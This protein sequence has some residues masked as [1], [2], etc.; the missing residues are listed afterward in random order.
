[1]GLSMRRRIFASTLCTLL[2]S[3]M[4]ICSTVFTFSPPAYAATKAQLA[5]N[6]QEGPLG[7]TLTLTGKNF[8][9][10]QV[11]FSY[12]DPQNV[13]GMFTA[14]GDSNAQVQ[15]DGTFVTTN[16]IL[17]ASGPTGVWKILVTDSANT[18]SS[19]RYTAIAAPG[20]Q[21]AGTPSLNVNPTNG[22][23]GDSIHFTGTNWL[24][25]GTRVNLMLLIDT[26]T[27]PL[28]D[29]PAVSDKN[30]TIRGSFHLPASLNAS[31]VIVTAADIAT[32]ALRAQTVLIVGSA[33]PTPVTSPTPTTAT[34][35]ASTTPITVVTP[36]SSSHTALPPLGSDSA[37]G[38][39]SPSLKF[40]LGL[41][42]LIVSG[43]LAILALL[44]LFYWLPKSVRE[45]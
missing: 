44:I 15:S 16:L 26:T 41:S 20:E 42:L 28:F 23:V 37:N 29:A 32:G 34:P 38:P 11:T 14:P 13:P 25:E 40:V 1:M 6:L 19:V 31:Q 22:M 45:R 17:P 21:T 5:L 4:V 8:P 43:L 7:V 9:Q 24:P 3:G 27:L 30:G 18:I 39:S 10:G 33:T 2:L 35:I 36:T 12:I